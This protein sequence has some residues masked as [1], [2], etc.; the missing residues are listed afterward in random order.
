MP[1]SSSKANELAINERKE[2]GRSECKRTVRGFR[3]FAAHVIVGSWICSQSE[4]L[5]LDGVFGAL[6]ALMK[7]SVHLL[8]IGRIHG[9]QSLRRWD[10]LQ[11]NWCWL[12]N[13]VFY[14]HDVH[15]SI[16]DRVNARAE[17][18]LRLCSL[19]TNGRNEIVHNMT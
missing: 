9:V 8:G 5:R 19:S 11:L 7:A 17:G 2:K 13:L 18:L 1:S 14:V 10:L 12:H 6:F 15:A 3:H 16:F 4:E